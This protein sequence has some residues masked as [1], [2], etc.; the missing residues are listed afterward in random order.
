[1]KIVVI[2]TFFLFSGL[3]VKGQEDELGTRIIMNSDS[4]KNSRYY[5][6]TPFFKAK[7]IYKKQSEASNLFPEQLMSSILSASNQEWVNYNT[8]GG[9][10]KSDIKSEN[11]FEKVKNID[12]NNTFFELHSKLEFT[13]NGEEMAIIKFFYNEKNEKPIAGSIVMKKENNQWKTISTPDTTI[14]ATALMVFKADIMKRMLIGKGINRMENNLIKK[15]MTK[16]GFN[17]QKLFSIRLS[18]TEKKYFTNPL[19]W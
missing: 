8:S 7:A 13:S 12:F 10:E 2:L 9:S 18:E 5:I 4:F 14:I 16:E 17:F 6:Y 3:I 15:V 1:M 11:H 19:N